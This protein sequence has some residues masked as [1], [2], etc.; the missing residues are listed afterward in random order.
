MPYYTET[1]PFSPPKSPDFRD[2]FNIHFF[3][4][5]LFCLRF[6]VCFMGLISY[7]LHWFDWCICVWTAHHQKYD[8]RSNHRYSHKMAFWN[9]LFQGLVVQ[10]M[11]GT[12]FGW[13]WSKAKKRRRFQFQSQLKAWYMAFLGFCEQNKF[14]P[15]FFKTFSWGGL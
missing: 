9:G 3:A 10:N 4:P 12:S 8:K 1:V 2:N 11:V 7:L 13:P 15:Q 6:G 5:L 14:F